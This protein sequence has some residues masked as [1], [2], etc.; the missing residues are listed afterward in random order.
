MPR[1]TGL[2]VHFLL[3]T[4]IRTISTFMNACAAVIVNDS[5]GDTVE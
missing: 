3:F 2:L 5:I 1:I 4:S